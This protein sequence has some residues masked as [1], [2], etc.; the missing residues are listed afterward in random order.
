MELKLNN[1]RYICDDRGN[2]E[3]AS[4]R[5]E[6]LA[7]ALFKLTARR[8]SF[9][10]LP[11]LGSGMYLLYKEKKSS[12]QSAALR[13]AIEALSDEP[14]IQVVSVNAQAAEEEIYVSAELICGG[15]N[16]K[17]EFTV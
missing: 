2:P 13:Y 7:R 14:D 1:G 16:I 8:G 9:P 3:A 17:L 10:F 5:E 11:D 6:L 15:D 12:L 4:G